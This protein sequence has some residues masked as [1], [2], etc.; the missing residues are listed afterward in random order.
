M[1]IAGVIV[2]TVP[3]K[4]DEVMVRLQEYKNVTTYG[5]HKINHIVAVLE[6]DSPDELEK[7]TDQLK[8]QIPNIIGIYPAYVNFE[9]A[10]AEETENL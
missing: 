6:G 1:P 2:L 3:E 4:A 7:L 5:S 10:P 8:E 9:D